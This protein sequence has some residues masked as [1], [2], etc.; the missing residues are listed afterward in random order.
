M[1][2]RCVPLLNQWDLNFLL[3]DLGEVKVCQEIQYK[4]TVNNIMYI[5]IASHADTKLQEPAMNVVPYG[6]TCTAYLLLGTK[7]RLEA[8]GERLQER[9]K[10]A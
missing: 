2:V 3:P 8:H 4:N 1:D 9:Q 7:R 5:P 6:S 10:G